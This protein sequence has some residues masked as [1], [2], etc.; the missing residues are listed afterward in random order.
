M[1]KQGHER[2]NPGQ[3]RF[4]ALPL[5]PLHRGM[6]SLITLMAGKVRG[7]RRQPPGENETATGGLSRHAASSTPFR[8]GSRWFMPKCGGVPRRDVRSCVPSSARSAYG[9]ALEIG[10]LRGAVGGAAIALHAIM[11]P[12]PCRER[13]GTC[14][15]SLLN[16]GSAPRPATGREGFTGRWHLRKMHSGIRILYASILEYKIHATS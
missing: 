8:N 9:R 5:A 2:D 15:R 14:R 1:V 4:P 6:A 12:K 7:W 10:P 11:Y 13:P 16:P 3:N